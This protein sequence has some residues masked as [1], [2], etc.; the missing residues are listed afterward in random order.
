MKKN[1]FIVPILVVVFYLSGNIQ[2]KGQE[3]LAILGGVNFQNLNG[4]DFEGDKLENDMI[5][6]YHIGVNFAIPV[7]TEFYFQPGV[8]LSTKG[9]EDK[10][11]DFSVKSNFSY[12]EV[13]LNLVYKPALGNGFLVLGFGPYIGYAVM[14]KVTSELGSESEET[15][16]EFQNTV[17]ST[18]SFAVPYARAID[19]GANILFGYEMQNGIFLQLNSQF[20][21]LNVN[22]EDKRITDDKTMVKHTGFGLSLGYRF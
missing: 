2:A 16:I 9:A 22:P 14:G 20:G 1:L 8:M 15:D 13:P 21:M 11:G 4:K 18:D 7:A 10:S 19:A 5:I 3:G 12:I 6:G 17:E